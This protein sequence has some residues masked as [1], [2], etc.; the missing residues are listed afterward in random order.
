MALMDGGIPIPSRDI[1]TPPFFQSDGL[2]PMRDFLS[3]SLP[4]FPTSFS[5]LP[6]VF[7]SLI[8]PR[9]TFPHGFYVE[10]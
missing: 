7:L 10:I 1:P 3:R 6:R 4:P 2:A 8:A 9:C 5:H